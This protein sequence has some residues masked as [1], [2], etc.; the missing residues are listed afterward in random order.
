MVPK[1][2]ERRLIRL[3]GERI[4]NAPGSSIIRG[5]LYHR[6]SFPLETLSGVSWLENP[7]SKARGHERD[8]D[9]RE[10]ASLSL[11]HKTYWVVDGEGRERRLRGTGWTKA[12]ELWTVAYLSLSTRPIQWVAWSWFSCTK[13]DVGWISFCLFPASGGRIPPGNL[14]A[15]LENG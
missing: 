15:R 6:K 2:E 5:Y 11:S 12:W 9:I 7:A 14:V 13:T 10:E 4:P 3:P 8:R 1:L